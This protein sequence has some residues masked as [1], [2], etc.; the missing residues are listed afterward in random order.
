MIPRRCFLLCYTAKNI[1]NLGAKGNQ[2]NLSRKHPVPAQ[3]R[4]RT[5]PKRINLYWPSIGPMS[6]LYRSNARP[7]PTQRRR[8]H[9]LNT[10]PTSNLYRSNIGQVPTPHHSCIVPT[11][12][13]YPIPIQ[14][15]SKYLH[16][17]DPVLAQRRTNKFDVGPAPVRHWPVKVNH[18]GTH[19]LCCI[20][21]KSWISKYLRNNARHNTLY[22]S[23][24]YE[25]K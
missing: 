13:T 16:N 7:V 25:M 5:G 1:L 8:L 15:Q 18:L 6:N 17:V 22:H 2:H 4:P 14:Y 3:H 11:Q 12:N 19:Y 21:T 23:P 10:V 20:W 24:K 9:R